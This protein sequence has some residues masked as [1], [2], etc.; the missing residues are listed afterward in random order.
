MLAV[1]SNDVPFMVLAFSKAVALDAF[2]VNAPVNPVDVTEVNPDI[3][4]GK[5][6]VKVLPLETVSISFAVPAIVNVSVFKVILCFPPVSPA[7]SKS[8]IDYYICFY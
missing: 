2:P 3:V 6:I 4:D 1:P 8:E 5:P 7:K